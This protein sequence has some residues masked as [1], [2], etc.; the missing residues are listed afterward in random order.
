MIRSYWW[1]RVKLA[2]LGGRR[3]LARLQYRLVHGKDA[4]DRMIAKADQLTQ[5]MNDIIR[6]KFLE[7]D[8]AHEDAVRRGVAKPMPYRLSDIDFPG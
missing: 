6:A 1:F 5:P 3:R 8:E 7:I 2:C 4:L